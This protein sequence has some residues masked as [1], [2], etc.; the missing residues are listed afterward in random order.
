MYDQRHDGAV[1]SAPVDESLT[2]DAV[3][4]VLAGLAAVAE[5]LIADTA[6]AEQE[7]NARNDDN[8]GPLERGEVGPGYWSRPD[9]HRALRSLRLAHACHAARDL[10]DASRHIAAWWADLAC[11]AVLSAAA[12]QPVNRCRAAAADPSAHF[13]DE[14]LR[15]L[16]Y[17]TDEQRQLAELAAAVA[18]PPSPYDPEDGLR[19]AVADYVARAGFTPWPSPDGG[20][21]FRDDII[22]PDA[23]LRRLWAGTWADHRL[24][25]LPDA[26]QLDRALA[27]LDLP[28]AALGEILAATADVDDVLAV[29]R[30]LRI[31]QGEE[32]AAEV[33]ALYDH[34]ERATDILADYAR[35]LTRHLPAIRAAAASAGRAPG[36]PGA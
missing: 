6:A 25:D 15:H 24:P 8:E 33:E 11:Y 29:A 3:D 5:Q 35:T 32:T 30:R 31:D 12:G 17:P 13:W 20:V 18:G 23:R 34:V 7:V 28:L 2:D 26:A 9:P 1:K 19:A 4:A 27:R 21:V 36:R 10:R 16:P 22:D 14:E